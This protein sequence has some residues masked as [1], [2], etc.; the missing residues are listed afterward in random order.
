M[1]FLKGF[2]IQRKEFL[3][4]KINHLWKN[5]LLFL[6]L[7]TDLSKSPTELSQTFQT[8]MFNISQ[9]RWDLGDHR[10]TENR[11]KTLHLLDTRPAGRRHLLLCSGHGLHRGTPWPEGAAP[12]P[13]HWECPGPRPWPRLAYQ[14][15]CRACHRGHAGQCLGLQMHGVI[16]V[17][18][19]GARGSICPLTSKGLTLKLLGSGLDTSVIMCAGRSKPN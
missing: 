4:W 7:F 13:R 1:F 12:P 15:C 2:F 16:C 9:G 18:L 14:F 8:G 10:C 19:G 6:H 5:K 17:C 11:N 3:K